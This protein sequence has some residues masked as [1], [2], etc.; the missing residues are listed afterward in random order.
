MAGNQAHDNF[1]VK[2]TMRLSEK[3]RI[4]IK[5]VLC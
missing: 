4:F 5:P 2:K 1:S 3:N